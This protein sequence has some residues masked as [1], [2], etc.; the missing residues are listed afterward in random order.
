[1]F[2][3]HWLADAHAMIDRADR[4]ESQKDAVVAVSQTAL[5]M[6]KADAKKF[7]DDLNEL[8]ERWRVKGQSRA[9]ARTYNVLWV[10]EPALEVES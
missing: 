5:R 7:T 2:R 1:M 3:T 10:L 8:V 4:P 6:T 9:T